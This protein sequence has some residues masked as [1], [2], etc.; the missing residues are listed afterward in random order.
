MICY[1]FQTDRNISLKNSASHSIC[2]TL[3]PV[4]RYIQ[5]TW[6]MGH[7]M[8]G[9]WL[10]HH[11]RFCSGLGC[12]PQKSVSGKPYLDINILKIIT[13]IIIDFVGWKTNTFSVWLD[14]LTFVLHASYASMLVTTLAGGFFR[15]SVHPPVGTSIPSH[16]WYF[17]NRFGEFHFMFTWT[18]DELIRIWWLKIKVTVTTQN[19]FLEEFTNKLIL[20]NCNWTGWPRH[21]T[22]GQQF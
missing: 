9:Q 20:I 13:P 2:T 6:H 5:N 8:S 15:L 17:S 21:T 16:L 10:N 18:Q 7:S 12:E 14:H 3:L 19:S 22:M 1:I 4:W 11:L